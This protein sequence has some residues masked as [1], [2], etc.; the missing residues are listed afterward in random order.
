[1]SICLSCLGQKKIQGMGFMGE[2]DCRTCK[3]TGVAPVTVELKTEVIKAPESDVITIQ[4]IEVVERV[5]E[6]KAE[7]LELKV[8]TEESDLA[9]LGKSLEQKS[10]CF[11]PEVSRPSESI[12][13]KIKRKYTKSAK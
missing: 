8:E 5:W 11:E 3:G 7:S 4:S 12:A 13:D 6:P 2:V 1:M 10:N 9:N